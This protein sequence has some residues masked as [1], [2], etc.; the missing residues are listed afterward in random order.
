[1]V[2]WFIRHRLH[3]WLEGR[4]RPTNPGLYKLVKYG[5]TNINTPRY[6]DGV[7]RNDTEN[8]NYR[9]LFQQICNRI[10]PQSKVLDV[11]CGS[12]ILARQ[13]RDTCGAIVTALDFSAHACSLLASD[14]FETIVSTLP[15]I[16]FPDESFDFAVCTEVLEHLD[17]PEKT[18]IQMFRIV[19]RGGSVICSVPDNLLHPHQEL[20]HQRAFTV[21]R[22][23]LLLNTVS[24]DFEVIQGRAESGH[25][26]FLLGILKKS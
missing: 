22:F 24:H 5:R 4:L 23:K 19:R 21:T 13:L 25:P 2:P 26:N 9:E 17:D 14:G 1:L 3:K 7:W 8:R 16:P 6:W 20:E 10:P 18:I 11:G 12:G 15:A